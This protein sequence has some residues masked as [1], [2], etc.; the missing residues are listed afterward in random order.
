MRTA[1][2]PHWVSL[3]LNLKFVPQARFQ[4]AI[5]AGLTRES[6]FLRHTHTL[7]LSFSDLSREAIKYSLDIR[8]KHEY[9]FLFLDSSICFRMTILFYAYSNRNKLR[10]TKNTWTQA[11][12]YLFKHKTKRIDA[13]HFSFL[14]KLFP[15]KFT[16]QKERFY[17]VFFKTSFDSFLIFKKTQVECEL[18]PVLS[19]TTNQK[20]Y[21]CLKI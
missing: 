21:F 9:D 12:S 10:L 3:C 13:W 2:L 15:D 5:F 16:I 4:I 11:F 7:T 6:I 8:V 18:F 20:L 14:N 1:V 19:I 17:R